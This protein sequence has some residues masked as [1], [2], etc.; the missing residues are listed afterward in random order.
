VNTVRFIIHSLQGDS[1]SLSLLE[2]LWDLT[3]MSTKPTVQAPKHVNTEQ[4]YNS[5]WVQKEVSPKF[6]LF[7]IRDIKSHN[8]MGLA[9]LKK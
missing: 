5:N 6:W 8:T 2:S 7:G 3:L 4:N 9:V 1:L